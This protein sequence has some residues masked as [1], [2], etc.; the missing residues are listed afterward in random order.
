M[1]ADL[2]HSAVLERLAAASAAPAGRI[3][4]HI[5]GA[6][7][8]QNITDSDAVCN[9]LQVLEHCQDVGEDARADR[10]YIPGI[11]RNEA[12]APATGPRVREA[13]ATHVALARGM[14]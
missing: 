1:T 8:E 6:A 9:A 10:V 2:S 3:V 13:V 5:A 12:L 7:T 11:E 14:M 4:L